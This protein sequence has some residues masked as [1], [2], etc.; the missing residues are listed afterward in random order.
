[1]DLGIVAKV[2]YFCVHISIFAMLVYRV[3]EFGNNSA[4]VPLDLT[5]GVQVV[6]VCKHIF[7]P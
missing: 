2:D 4:V 3:A 7:N 5:N 1:M 6:C